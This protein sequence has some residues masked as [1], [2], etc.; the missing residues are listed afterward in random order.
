[1]KRKRNGFQFKMATLEAPE[2]T[3]SKDTLSLQ[4]RMEQLP[5]KEIQTS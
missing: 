2:I 1:M 4:L 3:S 5:L